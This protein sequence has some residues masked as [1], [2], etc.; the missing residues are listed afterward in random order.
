MRARAGSRLNSRAPGSGVAPGDDAVEGDHDLRVARSITSSFLIPASA[1]LI[2]FLGR[3][4]AS[5]GGRL[6]FGGCGINVLL[7][8]QIGLGLIRGYDPGGDEVG[9]FIQFRLGASRRP[10]RGAVSLASVCSMS[11]LQ[12][13]YIRGWR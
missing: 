4:A 9:I 13:R 2:L 7:G 11:H 6:I 12:L 8:D 3:I 10:P 1:A 5:F